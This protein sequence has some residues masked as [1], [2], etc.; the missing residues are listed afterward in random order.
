MF[1]FLGVQTKQSQ[2]AF[3]GRKNKSLGYF[4]PSIERNGEELQFIL[5]HL[6]DGYLKIFEHKPYSDFNWSSRLKKT[7]SPQPEMV[8]S[9]VNQELPLA[10]VS[11]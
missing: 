4:A 11:F 2:I 9:A 8:I 5:E 1:D 3:G 10:R 7:V 6:P